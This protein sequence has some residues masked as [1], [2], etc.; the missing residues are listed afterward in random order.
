VHIRSLLLVVAAL[1][2]VGAACAN[3]DYETGDVRSRL[4]DAGLSSEQ[5]SCVTNGLERRITDRALNAHREPTEKE[6]E[7]AQEV[8]DD[9]DVDVTTDATGSS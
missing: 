7:I 4:V 1:A 3:P 5:A 2:A 9:C 8:F 6:R